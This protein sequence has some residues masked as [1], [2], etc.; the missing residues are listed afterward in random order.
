M[1][2]LTTSVEQ[3]NFFG[4]LAF[5]L[6]AGVI[7][8]ASWRRHRG[9]VRAS[10]SEPAGGDLG[11]EWV[12]IT[13]VVAWFLLTNKVWSP[14]FDLWLV[15]LLVLTARR[16]WPVAAFAVTDILVYWLE[17]WW[18]ARR[19]EFTPSGSFEALAA[20]AA[21]RAIVLV[22][23]IVLAVRDQRPAWMTPAPEPEP[24]SAPPVGVESR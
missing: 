22:G 24:A 19:A 1:G 8:W 21:L 5:A 10:G 16:M 23:I 13:P 4:T 12:L 3:R 11:Y 7:V 17:F 14:Q 15:P 18:L 2:L 6:G 9:R 20:V